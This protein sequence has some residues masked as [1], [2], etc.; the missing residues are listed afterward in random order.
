M[1]FKFNS[2]IKQ[3]SANIS[4]PRVLTVFHLGHNDITTRKDDTDISDDSYLSST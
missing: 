4:M 3:Y 2:T 1:S